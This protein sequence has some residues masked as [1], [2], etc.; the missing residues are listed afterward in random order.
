MAF[1]FKANDTFNTSKV[2]NNGQC[3]S[4]SR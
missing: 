1:E 3:S 4:Y 2:I